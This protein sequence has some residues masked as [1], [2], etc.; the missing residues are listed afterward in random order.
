MSNP[1]TARYFKADTGLCRRSSDSWVRGLHDSN[2][3][4][5]K[6]LDI[7][8]HRADGNVVL[9]TSGD[10]AQVW[11]S[12]KKGKYSLF[13]LGSEVL[14]LPFDLMSRYRILHA[15]WPGPHALRKEVQTL[16]REVYVPEMV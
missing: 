11:K 3:W 12:K 7:N 6:V 16:L 5:E 10:G 15:V 9:M 14:N 13:F 4:K 8:F 2:L 1:A